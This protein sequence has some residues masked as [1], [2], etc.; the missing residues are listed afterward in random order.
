MNTTKSHCCNI[1]PLL[2][3]F[4][5]CYCYNYVKPYKPPL[6]KQGNSDKEIIQR[7]DRSLLT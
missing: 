1:I 2:G 3:S 7:V 6:A 5:C 4:W